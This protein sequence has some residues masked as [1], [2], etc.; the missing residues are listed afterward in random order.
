MYGDGI[1]DVTLSMAI[2]LKLKSRIN[3]FLIHGE[4]NCFLYQISGN[5]SLYYQTDGGLLT[6]DEN[7][8]TLLSY[9]PFLLSACT[10]SPIASSTL[11]IMPKNGIV[12]WSLLSLA[13]TQWAFKD[14]QHTDSIDSPWQRGISC[15]WWDQINALLFIILFCLQHGVIFKCVVT[16][17]WVNELW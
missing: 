4:T 8:M 7:M 13:V 14:W 16:D 5:A 11:V 10:T 15:H 12:L 1:R 6:S 17:S 2:S 9:I 3:I